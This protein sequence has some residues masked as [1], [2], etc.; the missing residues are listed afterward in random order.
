MWSVYLIWYSLIMFLIFIIH[1][2]FGGVLKCISV[3]LIYCCPPLF[4]WIKSHHLAAGLFFPLQLIESSS[5]MDE[6]IAA[7]LKF[8]DEGMFIKKNKQ[9]TLEA[10]ANLVKYTW[11]GG[12]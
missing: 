11:L 10:V 12:I 5:T 4:S 7:G 3:M 9:Q 2:F 6:A 8:S 1:V